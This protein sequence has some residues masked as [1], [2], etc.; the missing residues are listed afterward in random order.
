M[1]REEGRNTR[2]SQLIVDQP[3]SGSVVQTDQK[4]QNAPH[5]DLVL[6]PGPKWPGR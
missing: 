6:G 3:T 5:L 4:F 1:G 2:T